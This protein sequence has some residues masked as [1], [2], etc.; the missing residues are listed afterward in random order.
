MYH[1]VEDKEFL[2][3]MRNLCSGIINELVQLINNEGILKVQAHMVG[4]GDKNLETQNS[5]EPIDLDYN[6]S[7]LKCIYYDINDCDKIKEYIRKS[8][9]IVLNRNG[10]G[11]CHDSTSALTTERRHFIHGNDTEFSIDLCIIAESNGKWYR[12]IHEKTGFYQ[13][14]RWFWNEG[15]NSSGLLKKVKFLKDRHH[16]NEVRDVYLEKKNMYLR[17]NDYNHPSF[18]CYIETINE[19]YNKYN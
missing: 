12:L 16:W 2:K 11:D 19:V 14:D 3:R 7:L 4:S 15:K 9:N 5:N 1:Y 6:I 13:S 8:F 17:R 10:W 18:N